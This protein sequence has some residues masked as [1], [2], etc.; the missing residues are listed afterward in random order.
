MAYESPDIH[1]INP[2]VNIG[3]RVRP[4]DHSHDR[5][6]KKEHGSHAEEPHDVVDLHTEDQPE[7]ES[8]TVVNEEAD[9]LDLSA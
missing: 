9:G 3:D 5:K 7:E 2:Y 1:R 6:S 8:A 4:T